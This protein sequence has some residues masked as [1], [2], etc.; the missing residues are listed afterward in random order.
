MLLRRLQHCSLINCAFQFVS[1]EGLADLIALPNSTIS[2]WRMAA[3]NEATIASKSL[4][5]L[6]RA[7][8]VFFTHRCD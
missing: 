3:L 5:P 1:G 6:R 7:D 4:G 2:G 8:W